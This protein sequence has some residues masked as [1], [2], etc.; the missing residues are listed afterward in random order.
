MLRYLRIA[1]SVTCGILCL[2]LIVMWVTSYVTHYRVRGYSVGVEVALQYGVLY[3][4]RLDVSP[5]PGVIYPFADVSSDPAWVLRAEGY[6]PEFSSLVHFG[7]R[8]GSFAIPIWS[9]MLVSGSFAFS[10]WIRWRFSLRTLLIA[11]T[12]VAVSLGA[13]V[14]SMR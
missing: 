9:L 2:V 1:F 14:Y 13:I 7:M 8:Y 6:P 11:M 12:L 4:E 3:F 5:I 10:P